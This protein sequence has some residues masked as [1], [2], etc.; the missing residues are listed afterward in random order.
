MSRVAY[1]TG[2]ENFEVLEKLLEAF[3]LGI[4]N[5]IVIDVWVVII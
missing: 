1:S 2:L 4:R 5:S 3:I